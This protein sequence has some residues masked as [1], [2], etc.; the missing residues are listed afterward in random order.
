[1]E[2][3]LMHTWKTLRYLPGCLAVALLST[4]CL[5]LDLTFT[6]RPDGRGGLEMT[7]AI[8]KDTVAAYA[9]M[10]NPMRQQTNTEGAFRDSLMKELEKLGGKIVKGAYLART[11]PID[12]KDW[13]GV[14]AFFTVED[15][16]ALTADVMAANPM[17]GSSGD[18]DD[19]LDFSFKPGTDGS[20][21]VITVKL[22]VVDEKKE[23]TPSEIA[24]EGMDLTPDQVKALLLDLR[25]LKIS[26][27]I[28]V[29]GELLSSDAPEVAGSRSILLAMDFDEMMASLLES[30]RLFASPSFTLADLQELGPE[31][32]GLV[33]PKGSEVRIEFR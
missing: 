10:M 8:R 30:G 5:K 13:E 1:M 33:M 25:G 19:E 24:G 12:S 22:P 32:P 16:N 23:S 6:I 17:S 4:S 28:E 21:A 27:A 9:A 3:F 14:R 26:V 20:P 11:E 29:E 31:V 18:G 15:V 7:A 2:A